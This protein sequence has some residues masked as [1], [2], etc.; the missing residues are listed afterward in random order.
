MASTK[1]RKKS[2]PS[3]QTVDKKPRTEAVCVPHRVGVSA[4]D[5]AEQTTPNPACKLLELPRE[6]RDEIYKMCLPDETDDYDMEVM[7][8][9]VDWMTMPAL[10]QTCQQIRSEGLKIGL[11]LNNEGWSLK[12]TDCNAASLLYWTELVATYFPEHTSPKKRYVPG[13]LRLGEPYIWLWGDMDIENLRQWC[14]WVHEGR[15]Q[16]IEEPH[17]GM[18]CGER[19]AITAAQKIAVQFMDKPWEDCVEILQIVLDMIYYSD[20]ICCKGSYWMIKAALSLRT[21]SLPLNSN[22][23]KS[24]VHTSAETVQDYFD[25]PRVLLGVIPQRCVL[26]QLASAGVALW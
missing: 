13:E 18:S 12:I 7:S 19:S 24:I 3:E 8:R 2:D 25:V 4:T 10:L 21:L 5:I 9:R 26:L 16:M 11:F 22:S 20:C 23:F 15:L 6:L 1:K 17:Y 14:C